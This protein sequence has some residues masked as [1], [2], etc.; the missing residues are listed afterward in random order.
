MFNQWS[1]RN[2]YPVPNHPPPAPVPTVAVTVAPITSSVPV[3]APYQPAPPANP[4]PDQTGQ[5]QLTAVLQNLTQM[6]AQWQARSVPAQPAPVPPVVLLQAPAPAPAPVVPAPVVA[7]PAPAPAVSAPPPTAP[8]PADAAPDTYSVPDPERPVKVS[9]R[10]HP[11][12]PGSKMIRCSLPEQSREIRNIEGRVRPRSAFDRRPQVNQLLL[13]P[14]GAPGDHDD[15]DDEMNFG[16]AIDHLQENMNSNNNVSFDPN[17]VR[18][19]GANARVSPYR[20][21]DFNQWIPTLLVAADA[22]FWDE[23]QIKAQLYA[24]CEGTARF[25]LNQKPYHLWNTNDMIKTLRD[26]LGK[27][28]SIAQVSNELEGVVLKPNELVADL[29]VRIEQI[30]CKADPIIDRRI[31]RAKKQD[32]FLRAIRT[33]QPMF[34]DVHNSI[35]KSDDPDAA[36]QLAVEYE[37]QQGITKPWVQK[38]IED[39][40]AKRGFMPPATS[41]NT[42][43]DESV[44]NQ[45]EGSTEPTD[46]SNQ[47]EAG[48]QED[49]TVNAALLDPKTQPEEWW[50]IVA[51]RLNEWERER[52]RADANSNARRSQASYYDKKNQQGNQNRTN[53]GGFTNKPRYPFKP[54]GSNQPQQNQ[55]K[56]SSNQPQTQYRK[57]W[58]NKTS[59]QQNKGQG[60][61]CNTEADPANMEDL[62]QQFFEYLAQCMRSQQSP[63]DEPEGEPVEANTTS[64]PAETEPDKV[65]NL[66][67]NPTAQTWPAPEPIPLPGESTS[68]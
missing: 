19:Y 8:A 2:P 63:A 56:P 66:T 6:F 40:L 55:T 16:A 44:P 4:Q 5:N 15:T 12:V 36:L 27:R 11:R 33:N 31:L 50:P 38:Q 14:G 53:Q 10:L 30:A 60:Q 13:G 24:L 43:G 18:R 1:V 21:G 20:G 34:Y 64:E 25:I 35:V 42:H 47:D 46:E 41:V 68:A 54:S 48:S 3:T 61:N 22:N 9:T 51:E 29:M 23:H 62:R 59:Y 57:P 17:V 28:L 45:E 67:A 7:A 65:A 32:A 37:R 26:R 58:Q 39:E 49:G 52:R